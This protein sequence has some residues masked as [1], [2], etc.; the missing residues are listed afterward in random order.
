MNDENHSSQGAHPLNGGYANYFKIGHNLF[1]FILDFG[2]S[3]N[4]DEP[5]LFHTRIITSPVYAKALFE[6]LGESLGQYEQ[7]F[8]STLDEESD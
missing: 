4:E 6:L 3:Y 8:G 1:E 5:A 7:S 2:Q